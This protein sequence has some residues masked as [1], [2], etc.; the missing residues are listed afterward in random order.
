MKE[1]TSSV[2][3]KCKGTGVVTKT[4]FVKDFSEDQYKL[5]PI[6]I[7]APKK[8]LDILRT[9]ISDYKKRNKLTHKEI[10]KLLFSTSYELS[11]FATFSTYR[12]RVILMSSLLVEELFAQDNKKNPILHFKERVEVTK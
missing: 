8:G 12:K 4:R 10:G 9:Q 1:I 2:C 6:V 7:K 3:M 5:S 11:Y